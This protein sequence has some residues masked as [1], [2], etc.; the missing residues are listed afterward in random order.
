MESIHPRKAPKI[1]WRFL[2]LPETVGNGLEVDGADGSELGA[3]SSATSFLCSLLC[4]KPPFSV[5]IYRPPPLF[6]E[7]QSKPVFTPKLQPNPCISP[8]QQCSV[9]LF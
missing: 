3:P 5:G 4:F 8:A 2:S 6:P 7:Q 9:T 1:P